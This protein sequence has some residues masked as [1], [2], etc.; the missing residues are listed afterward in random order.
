[1]NWIYENSTNI[2]FISLILIMIFKSKI[3]SMIYGIKNI[4]VIELKNQLHKSKIQ[5]VDVR[6]KSEFKN[7]HIKEALNLP[8]QNLNN[9][10]FKKYNIDTSMPIYLICA[11][12]NRS[13]MA[14]IKLKKMGFSQIYNVSGGM[15]MWQH[16]N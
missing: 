13:L 3:L 6:T 9:I 10:E 8:L 2:I 5:L 4:D 15:M 7:K 16:S 12:G 1:M 11:S 14:S